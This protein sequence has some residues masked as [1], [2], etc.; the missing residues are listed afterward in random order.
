MESDSI[1]KAFAEFDVVG[2]KEPINSK[3]PSDKFAA[4]SSS[5]S[6]PASAKPTCAKDSTVPFNTEKP[7]NEIVLSSNNERRFWSS[8]PDQLLEEQSN[9][10]PHQPPDRQLG[11]LDTTNT[12][13]ARGMD[14]RPIMQRS[15]LK[16]AKHPSLLACVLL[17]CVAT[18][19]IWLVVN[20]YHQSSV[21]AE[22]TFE[23]KAAVEDSR[24]RASKSRSQ[25]VERYHRRRVAP[26]R[27]PAITESVANEFEI[28]ST[29]PQV[30]YTL[31]LGG[32]EEDHK[33]SSGRFTSST[34]PNTENPTSPRRKLPS[35]L[36]VGLQLELA[37]TE[38]ASSL[39]GPVAAVII[40]QIRDPDSDLV[41]PL[42]TV[43]QF[44]TGQSSTS[45]RVVIDWTKPARLLLADDQTISLRGYIVAEDGSINLPAAPLEGDRGGSVSKRLAQRLLAKGG[46]YASRRNT[47]V[48]DLV[49]SSY[50]EISEHSYQREETPI[51]VTPS[52]TRFSL[53]IQ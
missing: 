47:I 38:P 29:P 43:L 42:G 49:N 35:R 39:G 10:I 14:T 15:A 48:G 19:V 40:A 53:T 45:G 17:V 8:S 2:A 21:A 6:P 5:P 1:F 32:D 27:H 25:A 22:S 4:A 11:L 36:T 13:F 9:R 41:I 52:G 16:R 7:P 50:R 34:S 3:R 12:Y 46:Q 37:L 26:K 28:Q 23:S 51:L 31:T 30:S 18:I 33:G 24:N 44:E 20:W